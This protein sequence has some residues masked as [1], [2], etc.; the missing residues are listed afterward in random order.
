[1]AVTVAAAQTATARIVGAANTF[2]ATLDAKQRQSVL[3]AFDDKKQRARWSNFPTSFVPRAGV[4]LRELNPAQRSAALALVASALSP[5]GFEK[6]QH[7][8]EADEVNKIND[9]RRAWH[10]HT[11]PDGRPARSLH[12]GWKDRAATRPGKR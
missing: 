3:F 11:H 1:M 5:M 8:M 2:L 12:D 7:I 10:P 6:V 9:C 4:S